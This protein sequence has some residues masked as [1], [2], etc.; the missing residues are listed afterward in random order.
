MAAPN[1]LL[2]WTRPQVSAELIRISPWKKT[3]D[4]LRTYA[5][6]SGNANLNAQIRRITNAPGRP[7]IGAA[8][9]YNIGD[10]TNNHPATI[11]T[12]QALEAKWDQVSV[13]RGNAVA[14]DGLW[15]EGYATLQRAWD[16]HLI[17]NPELSTIIAAAETAVYGRSSLPLIQGGA[18]KRK[19]KKRKS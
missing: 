6:I 12:L 9:V 10:P 1:Y 3:V 5:A 18:T 14:N 16:T 4:L 17:S 2:G 7:G 13:K 15:A 19:H 8:D 11:P